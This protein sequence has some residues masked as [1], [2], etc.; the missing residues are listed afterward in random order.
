MVVDVSW[1]EESASD[2]GRLLMVAGLGC[3]GCVI[4]GLLYGR[5]ECLLS[6]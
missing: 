2:G 3:G 1:G 6:S 4:L 5:Q